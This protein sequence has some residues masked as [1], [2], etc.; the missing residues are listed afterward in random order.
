MYAESNHD[1]QKPK[2]VLARRTGHP[3]H[4]NEARKVTQPVVLPLLKP[5]AVVNGLMPSHKRHP[6]P[7][8]CVR[9]GV[10]QLLQ[11]TSK[12]RREGDSDEL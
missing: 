11:P 7:A 12:R 9:K 10:Q 6:H 8:D 5:M 3:H 2:Q 4:D 1:Q